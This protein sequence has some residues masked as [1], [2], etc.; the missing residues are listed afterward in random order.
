MS[1]NPFGY[2][3]QT[4]F[5]FGSQHEELGQWLT[6]NPVTGAYTYTILPGFTLGSIYFPDITT[7]VQLFAGAAFLSPAV[8]FYTTGAGGDE[9]VPLPS[10]LTSITLY[11][12][13][14]SG[15]VMSFFITS[16]IFDPQKGTPSAGGVYSVTASSPLASSGGTNPNISLTTPLPVADGG[17]G[18]ATPGLIEGSNIAITGTWP[19]QTIAINFTATY[20]TAVT[21]AV[22]LTSSGGST[23]SISLST[24]LA[25]IY[26]GTGTTTPG[27]IEGSGITITGS[28]P[29]QEIALGGGSGGLFYDFTTSTYIAGAYI[30]FGLATSGTGGTVVVN[31]AFPTGALAG[32]GTTYGGTPY[33]ITVTSSGTVL[34]FK[35]F[36]QAGTATAGIQFFFI[37][38]GY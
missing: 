2:Q 33:D 36:S 27:L 5:P 38:I 6:F 17:T 37:I 20:V 1:Y 22:P 9:T 7:P 3:K 24:P 10:G 35:V 11:A 30:A 19:N 14:A 4:F 12:P 23:P 29:N 16:A 28:F 15:A 26:G 18:T 25:V 21:A 31:P 13:S 32:I 8:P 34:T